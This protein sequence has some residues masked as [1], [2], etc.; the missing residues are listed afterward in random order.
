MI[1]TYF[2]KLKA[3]KFKKWLIQVVA[4]DERYKHLLFTGQEYEEERLDF[5]KYFE[6]GLSPW[7]ALQ[8]EYWEYG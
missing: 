1:G 8:E 7:Q 2:K 6:R 3:K 5:Y 4:H